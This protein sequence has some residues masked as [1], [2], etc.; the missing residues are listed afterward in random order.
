MEP[1][2]QFIDINYSDSEINSIISSPPRIGVPYTRHFNQNEEYFIKLGSVFTVPHLPIHHDV[3][4]KTPTDEYLSGIRYVIEQLFSLV[5]DLFS[6]LSYAFNPFEVLKPRFFKHYR[7]GGQSC[8]YFLTIDLFYRTQEDEV[9][10]KG[11][12]DRTARYRT[13]SLFLEGLFIPLDEIA[14][15]RTGTQSFRIKQTLSDTWIGETGRGYFTKGIWM[16]DDL[17]KFFTKL[18]VP[19]GVRLYPFYPFVCRY[20]TICE[21]VADLSPEY[22]DSSLSHLIRALEFLTPFMEDIQEQ[23]RDSQFSEEMEFFQNLKKDVPRYWDLVFKDIKIE[24]YL[25]QNDMREFK[26]ET[27]VE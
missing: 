20:K 3:N 8:L 18:L 27:L 5:P 12:N 16:D 22:R 23:L 24:T 10:E 2:S 9:V 19:K 25:N 4:K 1:I 6:D 11:S 14:T 13:S 15:E 26:V 21:N 7:V 17:T